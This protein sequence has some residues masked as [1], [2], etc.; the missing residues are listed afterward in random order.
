VR[1]R[2]V[3]P[4]FWADARIAEL[5]EGVRLFY[6]GLWMV[7]DDAGWLRWDPSQIANELYGYESRRKRERDVETFLAL[8]VTAGRVVVHEC[9]H[10]EVPKLTDHQHLSVMSKQVR[11]IWREHAACIGS[12][13]DTREDP[14]MPA[15]T[16][17]SPAG[18][19]NG[20]V[21]VKGNGNG[22]GGG[23]VNGKGSARSLA[24]EDAT[25]LTDEEN[26]PTFLR[27]VNQS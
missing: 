9:G 25:A 8:L 1:I 27:V 13:T 19:G 15:E 14:R 16:R 26:L 23:K 22:D 24:P 17:E 5:P 20:K 6:I 4:A 21:N 18:Q 2:Q 10:V 3:K 11:T 12:H 7:A